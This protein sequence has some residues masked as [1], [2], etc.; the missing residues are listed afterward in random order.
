MHLILEVWRYMVSYSI[1][2]WLKVGTFDNQM[3]LFI[4]S[5]YMA[6]NRSANLQRCSVITLQWRHNG[7]DGV[8]NHQPH[9]CLLNRLFQRRSKKTSKLRIIGLC[10]GNSPV[11]SPHK[12]PVTRKMF[13]SDD[14]IMNNASAMPGSSCQIC[15]T[16]SIDG[17]DPISDEFVLFC[18]TNAQHT[19]K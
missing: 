16:A 17:S 10:A 14:V 19:W 18:F 15:K 5:V 11:N 8:S 2:Y 6:V 4:I 1:T 9:D 7:R 13:P 12:W 3:L